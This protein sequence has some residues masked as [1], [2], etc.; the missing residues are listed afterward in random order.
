MTIAVQHFG[1]LPRLT[2][3]VL[4]IGPHGRQKIVAE[5]L[6]GPVLGVEVRHFLLGHI[7]GSSGL[8]GDAGCRSQ[9]VTR[10]NWSFKAGVR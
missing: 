1:D 9:L 2:K 8:D 4:G 3:A 7:V 6:D 5:L 10:K